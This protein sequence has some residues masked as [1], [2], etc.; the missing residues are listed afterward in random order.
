MGIAYLIGILLIALSLRVRAPLAHDA[1]RG[2]AGTARFVAVTIVLWLVASFG[3]ELHVI[4]DAA[5]A[6]PTPAWHRDLPLALLTPT[7]QPNA[8]TTPFLGTIVQLFAISHTALLVALAGVIG[9][10]EGGAWFVRAL[11]VGGGTALAAEA[12]LASVA[13]ADTYLYVAHG[14]SADA[15]R[16]DRMTP[17]G[18]DAVLGELW[19]R[20]FL[21]SAYGP[22]WNA[23]GHAV[24]S[25]S[26]DLPVQLALFRAVGLAAMGASIA[27]LAAM[28]RTAAVV[29]FALNPML[30]FSY[31]AQAH[32]DIVGVALV[33]VALALRRFP[34]AAI[35]LVAL[36]GAI[37]VPFLAVG[38]VV[39]AGA[40]TARA[41]VLHAA[42]AVALGLAFSAAFGGIEYVR[43]VQHVVRMTGTQLPLALGICHT[44]LALLGVAGLGVALCARRFAWGVP[45]SFVAFGQ[46]S[47]WQYLGWGIPYALLDGTQGVLY[48]STLPVAQYE[49]NLV[50]VDTPLSIATNALLAIGLGV[51]LVVSLRRGG[52]TPRTLAAAT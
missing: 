47:C 39:F 48:L 43:A 17:A 29:L 8:D 21:P 16:P 5:R 34:A 51:A 37:K 14:L 30:W 33:L 19:G 4:A 9:R 15:Y 41:R 6:Q 25:L 40:P 7:W 45:W 38:I 1:A 32:N 52:R 10:L 18:A 12:F 31:V 20:P 44:A 36:A 42:A 50:F 2:S 26:P 49:L 13:D 46:Y 35:V 3:F 11:V 23:I 27:A 24:A 22:L 28:R